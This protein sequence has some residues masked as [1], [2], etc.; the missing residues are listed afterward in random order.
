MCVCTTGA[1]TLSAWSMNS[2]EAMKTSFSIGS[3]GTEMTHAKPE[4]GPW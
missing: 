4:A 2:A 1:V 3:P